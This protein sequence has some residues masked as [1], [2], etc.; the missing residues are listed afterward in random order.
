MLSIGH[1]P[2]TL[3]TTTRDFLAEAFL[4][5]A[6]VSVNSASSDLSFILSMDFSSFISLLSIQLWT[7]LRFSDADLV[8]RVDVILFDFC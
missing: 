4:T 8:L 7:G 2:A 1:L 6:L 3:A 5:G